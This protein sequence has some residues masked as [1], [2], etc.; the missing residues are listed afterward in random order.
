VAGSAD[1][2]WD[3]QGSEHFTARSAPV[4]AAHAA[5]VL[6][7]L[8]RTRADLA[9]RLPAVPEEVIDVV[10]HGTRAQLHVAQPSL[11][12]VPP[13][14]RDVV[15]GRAAGRS[16]HLLTPRLH[17]D[18]RAAP[19]LYARL[20]VLATGPA[21]ASPRAGCAT[22]GSSTAPAT[23]SPGGCP[24][25]SRTSAGACATA[26]P[27]RSRR[28]CA[29]LRVRRRGG[30]A[31]RPRARAGGRRRPDRRPGPVPGLAAVWPRY[32]ERLVSR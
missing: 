31:A 5:D 9:D 4:D 6:A 12:A 30:R 21:C 15:L 20:A 3:E 26:R 27:R 19:A 14:L 17:R 29:T 32:L 22:R 16:I 23:G 13:S 7:A 28:R 18:A 8:E 25:W 2:A 1:V 24:R 10:L 11:L